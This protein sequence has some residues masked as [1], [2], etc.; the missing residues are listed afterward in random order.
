MIWTAI[1]L[2]IILAIIA[3]IAMSYSPK[4]TDEDMARGY[5]LLMKEK[6]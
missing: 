2:Y 6:K 1:I 3:L 5:I 4:G